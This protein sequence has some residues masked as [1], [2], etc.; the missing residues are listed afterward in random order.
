MRIKKKSSQQAELSELEARLNDIESSIAAK[1]SEIDSL[2]RDIEAIRQRKQLLA[3][4]LS[5]VGKEKER[6][7]ARGN[8]AM[9]LIKNFSTGLAYSEIQERKEAIKRAVGSTSTSELATLLDELK[10]ELE[11][12]TGHRATSAWEDLVG[13]VN[14]KH[15][16][17]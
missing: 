8:D 5:R 2:E 6:E 11:S 10:A 4:D 9:R 17:E 15:L 1:Q 14:Y 3:N 12:A 7:I 16:K 13:G